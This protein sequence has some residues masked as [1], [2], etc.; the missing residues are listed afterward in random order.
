MLCAYSDEGALV[1]G[2]SSEPVFKP[3]FNLDL[4]RSYPYVGRALAFSRERFM[5]EGGFDPRHG[6]LAPH[7]LL[8]RMVEAAGPRTI[9]HI[10]D[11]QLESEFSFA[12]WLSRPQVIEAS[13]GL[14]A[15]HLQ[16][17]GVEHRIVHDDLPLLN[18][19]DYL[20]GSRPLVS[21]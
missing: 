4:M 9:E 11:I 2:E 21:I 1:E 16:R 8:W 15:A 13:E 12:Q 18:R 6:E 19:I 5:A 20:H 3:D 7:D 10:A 17:I 14:V